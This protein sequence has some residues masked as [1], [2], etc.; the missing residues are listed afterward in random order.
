MDVFKSYADLQAK[1]PHKKS[2]LNSKNGLVIQTVIVVSLIDN[3]GNV[4]FFL[5]GLLN[6]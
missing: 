5:F 4:L 3:I 2:Y 1:S 6:E